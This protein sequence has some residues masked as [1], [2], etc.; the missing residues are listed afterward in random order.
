VLKKILYILF[1]RS[2]VVGLSLL[3]QIA[4]LFVMVV[5]FSEY[6]D[7][8]YWFCI[9]V[10]ISAA[11]AII[12]SRMEPGYKIAW[13]LIILP[14]PVFGGLFYLLVGGG[15]IPKHIQKRMQGIMD[16]SALALREDF[17]ADDLLPLGGDAVCQANYLEQYAAAPAYT[18]TECEYFPLGDTV[19]PRML[20]E[21]KKA[22]H[23]IFLEYFIIQPGTFW[24]S[25]L[26][27]LEEKAAQGVEIRLI[28]DD[29]GCMFT[30]PRD[31]DQQLIA[32][33]IQCRVFNRFVPVMTLRLNNRDHRK[34]LVID[35]K[36]G[37]TGGVNLADEYINLRSRFGHWKDSALLLEGD[38]VWSM[39]VMFLTMWDH[40][41][42]WDEDFDRFRP[43]PA[44]IRPWTG[45]VQPYTDAPLDQ[46]AVGQAVYL[47]MIA[48]AKNYIY[49]TTPYLIIDVA[50]NTALCNAAKSGVDV[51]IITPHIPDKRYVFEVT[52]AHY[53]PLLRAGV[54]IYE[55]TPGFIH[56]KNF[57]V[58]DRFATVGT[59]NLDYRSLFL[60]FENGVWLCEAPCIRDIRTDFEQTLK[61]CEPISL[62]RF[63]H[64]NI[65]LQIYRSVLRVFAPLM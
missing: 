5:T 13:L 52:R 59:V 30:L 40:C 48:K 47:N 18:N 56:A 34:I 61:K 28:Y 17:K 57:V 4:A 63:K 1:H 23:Y 38:A 65:L 3:I 35:G 20:E 12:S 51:R 21:L 14:F 16:K 26:A 2:V 19:F 49:I 37:F 58:D 33:G 32:K 11:V 45:Y 29:M 9:L 62:R 7:N 31:Y 22:E 41:C 6:A 43:S 39:T 24:D 53:P 60:H 64:L 46:E 15:H 42:G 54:Q 50:T 25:I 55:Y 44:P 10:S 36:V 8:F 27:I